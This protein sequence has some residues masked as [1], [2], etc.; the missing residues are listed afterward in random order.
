MKF[1][2]GTRGLA[3]SLTALFLSAGMIFS[4]WAPAR[5]SR[6]RVQVA[7]ATT[8]QSP[9]NK[10]LAATAATAMSGVVIQ[11]RSALDPD[12]LGFNIYRVQAGVRTRANREI[13]PGAIFV[14]NQR[15][16]PSDVHSYS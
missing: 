14:A 13:V 10:I 5:A 9:D 2:C 15:T 6:S 4:L 16:L 7:P 11:W 8:V 3:Q 1:F 12:N